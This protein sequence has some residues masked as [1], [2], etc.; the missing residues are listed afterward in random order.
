MIRFCLKNQESKHLEK[1]IPAYLLSL[2]K[3]ENIGLAIFETLKNLT[4]LKTLKIKF[5]LFWNICQIEYFLGELTQRKDIW[6]TQKTL[7][8]LEE[9]DSK[10]IKLDQMKTEKWKSLRHLNEN[11]ANRL[12]PITPQENRFI[13]ETTLSLQMNQI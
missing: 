6:W 5:G 8:S 12:Y 7:S 11:C 13:K 4:Q 1:V 2:L 10:W 9:W 3:M